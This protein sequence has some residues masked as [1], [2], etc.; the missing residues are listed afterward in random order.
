MKVSFCLETISMESISLFISSFDNESAES[1]KIN[2]AKML[3]LS[4]AL[5]IQ[6]LSWC[7][8]HTDI[9]YLLEWN[10]S[11]LGYVM[12]LCSVIFYCRKRD[13]LAF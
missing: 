10:N 7:R 13:S 9:N 8:G 11:V 4:R 12:V 5:G 6:S 2:M 3:F 1:T